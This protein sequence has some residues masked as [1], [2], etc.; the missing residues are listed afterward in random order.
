MVELDT[1]RTAQREIAP[2]DVIGDKYR[3]ERCLGEGGQG[4]VWQA[5][6]LL[7]DLPVAIK[8]VHPD[9]RDRSLPERLFREARAA[10]M[11][12]HP[13]IVRVL[14]LGQAP[15]G[16]PF[17]VMELL[18]GESLADRLVQVGRLAPERALRVLLPIADALMA[19]H[20]HGVVHRDVKPDNV[21]LTASGTGLQPK[22]LDFGIA[23]LTQGSLT[24]RSLTK[25]GAILGTPAYLSP[26]QAEGLGTVDYRS[27]IWS[28]CAMAYECLTG[29]VPFSEPKWLDL[30]RRILHDDP[31]PLIEFGIE[32][33]EL[34]QI[35]NRGLAKAPENRWPSMYE[36]GLALAEWLIARGVTEDVCGSALSARWLRRDSMAVEWLTPGAPIQKDTQ[37]DA[38]RPRERTLSPLTIGLGTTAAAWVLTVLFMV[39]GSTKADVVQAVATEPATPSHQSALLH[40]AKHQESPRADRLGTKPLAAS[41]AVV[42]VEPVEVVGSPPDV[43]LSQ[44]VVVQPLLAD[45]P[46]APSGG[47][48]GAAREPKAS[49]HTDV[50]NPSGRRDTRS[51]PSPSSIIGLEPLDPY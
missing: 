21:F 36:L 5:Q 39:L 17:L 44:G 20:A 15:D 26:E 3:F 1:L 18:K 45:A 51:R 35:V 11:L 13:A 34:W 16:N 12:G 49:A 28:F 50:S 7:L 6:N 27:D 33:A 47:T 43:A 42:L 38:E 41:T 24:P 31:K 48:E 30:R 10:A 32:D 14:D 29:V 4:A 2:G 8:I 25:S 40:G 23:R 9:S 46:G 19:A 37:K 22:L